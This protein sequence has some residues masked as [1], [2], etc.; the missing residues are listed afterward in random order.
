LHT[1]QRALEAGDRQA[2]ASVH[3]VTPE[4]DSGPVIIQALV[5]VQSDDDPDSLAARVLAGEHVI[6]PRAVAWLAEGVVSTDGTHSLYQ[7][8]VMVK[9]ASWY[10]GKLSNP[11][12]AQK[13]KT[14]D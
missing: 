9:P 1:H 7:G 2:G 6:F 12:T 11:E 13:K 4:I 3:F 8:S 14:P 5:D 10:N